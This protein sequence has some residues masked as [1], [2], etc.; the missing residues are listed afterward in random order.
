[1]DIAIGVRR[2]VPAR[3]TTSAATVQLT[4]W[5]EM[6]AQAGLIVTLCD[7]HPE[8]HVARSTTHAEVG[9]TGFAGMARVR[10]CRAFQRR[11]AV[12]A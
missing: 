3:P 12:A 11:C 2:S 5:V 10:A 6:S 9:D 1:M 4:V 8:E 7:D